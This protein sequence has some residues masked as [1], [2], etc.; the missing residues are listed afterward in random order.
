MTTLTTAH[1]AEAHAILTQMWEMREMPPREQWADL[2]CRA[3]DAAI[4]LK[5]HGLCQPVKV[6]EV[7]AAANGQE[8]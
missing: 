2:R 6:R 3:L 4:K 5:V 7:I 1:I 8:A